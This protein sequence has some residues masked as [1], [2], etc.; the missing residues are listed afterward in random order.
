MILS[1]TCEY[2]IRAVVYVALTSKGKFVSI[3]EI[4]DN[5]EISFHFLTKV[6]QILTQKNILKSYRG[7][8]GGVTLAC[9][10]D[11]ISLL[12]IIYTIDGEKIFKDC[13]LGLPGC[14]DLV[15]CPLHNQWEIDRELI[16]NNFAGL[17]LAQ[18]AKNF[19]AADL[20]LSPK[21]KCSEIIKLTNNI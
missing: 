18:L 2:G 12:E 10:A 7:P 5:L 16:K 14:G 11:K 6:L 1:K 20:R 13:I 3:K 17:T 21:G 4:S 8:N 15:P 19:L 9:S